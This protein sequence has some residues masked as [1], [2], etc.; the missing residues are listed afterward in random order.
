MEI[1]E[2]FEKYHDE[3]LIKIYNFLISAYR[4]SEKVLRGENY[5]RVTQEDFL[6]S[7]RLEHWLAVKDKNSWL[8]CVHYYPLDEQK[9][10]FSL[11]ATE[12][13]AAGHGIAS[14]L[15][16]HLEKLLKNRG[17]QYIQIEVL[18]PALQKV[19][20]KERLIKWYL[21]RGYHYIESKSFYEIKSKK[22]TAP[23]VEAVFDIFQKEL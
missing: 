4:S 13:S 2:N 20:S 23:I 21:N 6:R 5:T 7:M 9:W 15:I 17:V 22:Y 10:G 3:D 8:A 11:L 16:K 19:D 12:P 18:K 14:S 1:I